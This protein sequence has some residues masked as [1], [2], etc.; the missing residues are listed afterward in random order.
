M[1]LAFGAGGNAGP[2]ENSRKPA[3]AWSATFGVAAAALLMRLWFIAETRGVPW[4]RTP[5]PASDIDLHWQAA[6]EIR[7]AMVPHF[8][9]TEMSAPLHAV[10]LALEQCL[11]GESP[12]TL[13]L[14]AAPVGALT[15][16]LVHR[17][18]LD[19][20]GSP[21]TAVG[22]GLMAALLPSLIYFDTLPFKV[23]LEVLLIAAIL[24]VVLA[25]ERVTDIRRRMTLGASLG[26]LLGALCL[27]QL[28]ALAEM[29][30]VILFLATAPGATR[31]QR[32]SALV[33]AAAIVAGCL[34]VFAMRDRL[35]PSAA[36][37]MLPQAG[38][39][40]REGFR[41]DRV[42]SGTVPG[43]ASLGRDHVFVAR[44][45]AEQALGRAL[46][47]SEANAYHLRE[48]LRSIGDHPYMAIRALAGKVRLFC[49]NWEPKVH[50]NSFDR[51]RGFARAL[52][53]PLGFGTLM[54]LGALGVVRLAEQ[55][56]LRVLGLLCGL[57]GA[58]FVVNLLGQVTSRY[59]LHAVVPLLLLSGYGML[60]V[61]ERSRSPTLRRTLTSL[62][63]AVPVI[64]LAYGPL[65][66]D[67]KT[68]ATPLETLDLQSLRA[69]AK[70]T[71][72]A[73]IRDDD[74]DASLR[75]ASILVALRRD[76]EAFATLSTIVDGHGAVD[77]WAARAW[78]EYLLL[79]GDYDRAG[80]FVD[81]T[82]RLN[83]S[84][85]A[86]LLYGRDAALQ[87]VLDV[88]V[89]HRLPAGAN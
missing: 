16:A 60:L 75:R 30:A 2:A 73:T 26:L 38:V 36:H 3:T 65:P 81:R 72:L 23:S 86:R 10:V 27:S 19:C 87:W 40:M 80:S 11:A 34:G 84:L 85:G 54:V 56:E 67:I 33:P 49:N 59:R 64:F 6:R 9:L 50:A 24:F 61:V 22:V 41:P 52:R 28:N 76:S 5:A 55:R 13:R 51:L 79:L 68:T 44:I 62:I 48:A 18:A 58:V 83:P 69:E 47:P 74:E 37:T 1:T 4:F 31:R 42:G 77:L 29:G 35:G 71:E 46:T 45:L 32:L 57:I 15:A 39:H 7:H 70:L 21:R 88:L 20:T 53:A 66:A 25:L 43:M 89:L 82:T 17:L 14:V 12:L 8:A 78:L 63:A